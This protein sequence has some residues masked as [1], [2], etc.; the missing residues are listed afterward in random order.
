MTLDGK[1]LSIND[2]GKIVVGGNPLNFGVATCSTTYS[3]YKGL[4]EY[5]KGYFVNF[6]DPSQCVTVSH[7]DQSGATFGFQDCRFNGA[8]DVW[9]SQSFAW[10]FENNGGTSVK[11][12]YFNGENFNNNTS[13][14][15]LKAQNTKPTIDGQY[16]ELIADYTPDLTSVPDNQLQLPAYGAPAS[17]LPPRPASLSCSSPIEGQI[18]FNNQTSG[19]NGYNGPLNDKWE[20]Q[21]GTSTKFLFEQCD[22]P[23]SGLKAEGDYV[24]GRIRPGTDVTDGGFNCYFLTDD[25]GADENNEPTD[26]AWINGFQLQ[27][28]SYTVKTGLDLVK[29][30]KNDNTFN[31]VPFG[32]G[33]QPGNMYWY[34]QA[35]YD[36]E[37]G[38]TQYQWDPQGVGQVYISPSNANL[39]KFPPAKV[40]FQADN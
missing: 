8:G 29:Y 39:T 24:Y 36:S 11:Q 35:A 10:N 34:N 40:T 6:E 27:T 37:Y 13:I 32:N 16:G 21:S 1:P 3:G 23:A 33:S 17:A 9:S 20:P 19:S 14:Y 18:N 4:N 25:I 26:G 22:Y 5:S 28:C 7:L 30:N 15:T 38:V 2:S 12:V 31:Y